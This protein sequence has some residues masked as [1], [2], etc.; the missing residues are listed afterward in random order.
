MENCRWDV[1]PARELGVIPTFWQPLDK[2]VPMVATAEI[3]ELAA[4]VLQE[5]WSGHRVVE[6]KGPRRLA[7]NDIAA[8]FTKVL[9]RSVRM[10]IAPRDSWEEIFR[11]QGM[12]NP[13]PRM[14]MLDGF[15]EVWMEFEGAAASSRKGVVSL[16]SVLQCLISASYHV[17]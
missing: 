14:R 3:A 4:G 8:A 17:A 15:N 2:P 13:L 7:P 11:S 1:A 16:E 12:R 9:G 6:L 10:Q 5:P